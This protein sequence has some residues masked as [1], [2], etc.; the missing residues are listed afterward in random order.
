MRQQIKK[1]ENKNKE[2]QEIEKNYLDSHHCSKMKE[3]RSNVITCS[4]CPA[5]L[6]SA[7]I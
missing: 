5:N 7:L 2:P 3:E 6:K 1:H 4:M